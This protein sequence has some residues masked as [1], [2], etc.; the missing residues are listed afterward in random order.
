MSV[1]EKSF[2]YQEIFQEA[3]QT[4]FHE[5]REKAIQEERLLTIELLLEIKFGSEGLELMPEISQIYDLEQLEVIK[6]RFK[7][8]NTLDELRGLISSIK[9]SST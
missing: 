9:T 2:F 1:F 6:R 3:Y 7:T 5:A 4:S 8:L